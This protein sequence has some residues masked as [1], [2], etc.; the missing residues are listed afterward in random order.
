MGL[1]EDAALDMREIHEDLDD[2]GWPI[3]VTDPNGTSADLTGLTNDISQAIDPDTGAMVSG[4]VASV[5]IPLSALSDAGLGIPVGIADTDS[6]PWLV[7]FDDSTGV[8]WAFKVAQ[9]NPDRTIGL[10]VCL[11]EAYDGS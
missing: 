10:V 2:F 1:R 8:S 6:R 7:A 11:L 5:S 9:S 4:R 3:V